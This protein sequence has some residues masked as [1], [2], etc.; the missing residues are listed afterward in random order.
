MPRPLN[1]GT[2]AALRK[3]NV[4]DEKA[5]GAV[6]DARR[7]PHAPDVLATGGLPPA[8]VARFA[9]FAGDL[10]LLGRVHRR[11]AP[12]RTA[13][14]RYCHAFSPYKWRPRNAVSQRRFTML[15]E[16]NQRLFE[17]CKVAAENDQIC[18]AGGTANRPADLSA[19]Q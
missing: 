10:A 17:L 13:A 18:C 14:L 8:A 12:F 15:I 3:R 7:F 9:A 19:R 1:A 2:A 11:K 6:R 4:T 16:V 5:P